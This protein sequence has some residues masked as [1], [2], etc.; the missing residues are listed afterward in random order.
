MEKEIAALPGYVRMELGHGQLAA[1][2]PAYR[3]FIALCLAQG[4]RAALVVSSTGDPTTPLALRAALIG[5][6]D[7][8]A[9][10][11]F[12]L[13][14]VATTGAAQKAYRIS[15]SDAAAGGMKV[16]VFWNEYEA[17]AWLLGA[18]QVRAR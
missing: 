10:A 18:R 8:G 17:A 15:Q 2:G 11:G 13:A 12:K 9:R 1:V 14:L 5:I 7:L 3:E 16:K 6:R 4:A